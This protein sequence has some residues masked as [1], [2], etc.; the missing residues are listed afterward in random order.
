MECYVFYYIDMSH[1]FI[2]YNPRDS[3][4]LDLFSDTNTLR[5]QFECTRTQSVGVA[6]E[7]KINRVIYFIRMVRRLS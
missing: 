7:V 4:Y 3:L 2:Q 1:M 6:K 5:I